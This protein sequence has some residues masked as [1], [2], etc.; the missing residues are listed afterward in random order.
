MHN[1]MFD[2]RGKRLFVQVSFHIG[3]GCVP[4][5]DVQCNEHKG[6]T[7]LRTQSELRTK[8]EEEL[9]AA[10]LT[11]VARELAEQRVHLM[12]PEG[13]GPIGRGRDAVQKVQG[14]LEWIMRR[15]KRYD[16]EL[17]REAADARDLFGAALVRTDPQYQQL[18]EVCGTLVTE[19]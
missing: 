15:D 19:G 3:Q 4:W 18:R 11:E 10:G 5:I 6:W 1:I 2:Y 17:R 12:S 14:L 13:F 8:R 7:P 16:F 9:I